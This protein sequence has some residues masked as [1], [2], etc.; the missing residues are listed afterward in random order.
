MS[1]WTPSDRSGGIPA[2]DTGKEMRW[3]TEKVWTI[4]AGAGGRG[5]WSL[6]NVE[7]HRTLLRDEKGYFSTS[8]SVNSFVIGT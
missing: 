8:L 4:L 7:I 5:N 2:L 1:R 6:L 3:I